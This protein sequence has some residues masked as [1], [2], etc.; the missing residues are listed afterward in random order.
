MFRKNN[1]AYPSLLPPIKYSANIAIVSKDSKNTNQI[2]INIK[3]KLHQ[4][5]IVASVINNFLASSVLFI[6]PVRIKDNT[7]PAC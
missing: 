6:L 7:N 4:P 1:N 3:P 2:I 5:F